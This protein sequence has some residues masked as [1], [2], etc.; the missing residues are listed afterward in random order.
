MWRDR[1]LRLQSIIDA[2]PVSNG[3]LLLGK[4]TALVVII[5]VNLLLA[6]AVM[7]AYELL[8]GYTDLQVPLYLQM[9][10]L[11]HG[12]NFY[13][14]AALALQQLMR[15][16]FRQRGKV[17]FQE[18]PLTDVYNELPIA[19]HKG[20]MILELIEQWIGPAAL[21]TGIRNFLADHRY[22]APPYATVLD[23]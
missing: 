22:A 12:P 23:L 11:E 3:V 18:P 16:Y 13:I 20:G 10:F 2:T 6:M 15:D 1:N 7:I 14:T 17:D 19:R 4:L 21:L 8:N 5:T 9:L